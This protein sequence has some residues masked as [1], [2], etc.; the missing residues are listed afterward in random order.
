VSFRFVIS[1]SEFYPM[2]MRYLVQ[3]PKRLLSLS[4]PIY[5]VETCIANVSEQVT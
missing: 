1:R 5:P 4:V 3:S 2:T